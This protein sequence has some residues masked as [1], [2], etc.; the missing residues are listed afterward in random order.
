[1]SDEAIK[2]SGGVTRKAA[3]KG[4]GGSGGHP[5]ME[6]VRKKLDSI[7]EGTLPELE[8]LNTRINKLQAKSDPPNDVDESDEP[9]PDTEPEG[10]NA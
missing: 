7:R 10:G 8:S 6:A 4:G 1:M 5:I 2:R 3:R 9:I